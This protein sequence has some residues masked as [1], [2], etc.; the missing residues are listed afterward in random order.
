MHDVDDADVRSNVTP[1]NQQIQPSDRE[2]DPDGIG[3]WWSETY[4]GWLKSLRS[5]RTRGEYRRYLLLFRRAVQATDERVDLIV[6]PSSFLLTV[7]QRMLYDALVVEHRKLIAKAAQDFAHQPRADGKSVNESTHNLRLAAL[8]SFYTYAIRHEVYVSALN[9]LDRIDRQPRDLYGH[10]VVLDITDGN[11]D[12]LLAAIDISTPIGLRD[13]ALLTLTL[14]SGRRL[15]EIA[16]LTIGALATLRNNAITITWRQTKGGKSA[17]N[18]F[19]ASHSVTKAL[20]AWLAAYVVLLEPTAESAVF[21]SL[22]HNREMYLERRK[23]E[24]GTLKTGRQHQL[25]DAMTSSAIE[26]IAERHLGQSRFHALR[27]TFALAMLK[28]GASVIELQQALG[29]ANLAITSVYAQHMQR[30][31]NKYAELLQD[32]YAAKKE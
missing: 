14:Y 5:D 13:A 9:P 28:A 22:S 7:E 25:L 23:S 4:Y 12:E 19:A 2:M 1:T 15:S 21:P 8:A 10:A 26:A 29:H 32:I 6:P 18:T 31:E 27:H 24:R 17:A 11:V 20:R 30:D 3:A 16:H